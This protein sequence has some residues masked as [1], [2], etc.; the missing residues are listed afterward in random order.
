MIPWFE[1]PVIYDVR[2]RPSVIQSQSG[3][4]DLQMVSRR[5]GAD[6][7][8]ASGCLQSIVIQT[9]ALHPIGERG[10]ACAHAAKPGQA[11]G[12]LPH[13]RDGL[14]R[15]C[16]AL[17][18][19]GQ[20]RMTATVSMWSRGA[21]RG[22]CKLDWGFPRAGDGGTWQTCVGCSDATSAPTARAVHPHITR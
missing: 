8:A 12:D 19:P 16:P 4:R 13:A 14:R 11:A 9:S 7:D 18:H 3:S 1:R 6:L 5:L 15:A 20:F 2:A 17:N 22:C 21:A 10:P